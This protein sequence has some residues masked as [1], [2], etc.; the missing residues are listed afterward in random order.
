MKK[1][2]F[3]LL[4]SLVLVTSG[5]VPAIAQEQ[6]KP[7]KDTINMDTEATPMQY[8]EVEDDKSEADKGTGKSANGIIVIIVGA[9]LVVGAAAF[10]LLNKK[11]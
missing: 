1:S 7:V 6:P 10:F 2:I 8:Y 4:F 11:K 9:I 3:A 5:V